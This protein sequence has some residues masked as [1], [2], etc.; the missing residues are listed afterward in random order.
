MEIHDITLLGAADLRDFF[1]PWNETG[2][3]F[4]FAISW[5]VPMNPQIMAGIRIG[6]NQ[7]HADEYSRV[8]NRI[9]ELS[10]ELAAEIKRRGFRSK[11]LVASERSDKVN[12]K[13]NFPHKKC[14]NKVWVGLGRS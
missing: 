9:N 4:P 14:S 6:P 7:A 1:T 10:V 13:R 5:A 3:R 11:P 2:E 12:I 8:N